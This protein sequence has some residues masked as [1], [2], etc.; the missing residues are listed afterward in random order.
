MQQELSTQRITSAYIH[1]QIR[2]VHMQKI[3]FYY[4]NLIYIQLQ[5]F[6]TKQMTLPSYASNALRA[7]RQR[8]RHKSVDRWVDKQVYYVRTVD[9]HLEDIYGVVDA[10]E[11][12]FSSRRE[13]HALHCDRHR[14]RAR[15]RMQRDVAK[16][17]KREDNLSS[18]IHPRALS[19]RADAPESTR[20]PYR[21]G[22]HIHRGG[23][24]CT[25]LHRRCIHQ[26][27]S[28]NPCR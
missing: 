17:L 25:S 13:R 12:P 16:S 18:G 10:V 2:E 20:V 7:S 27:A 22:R 15:L 9:R 3:K 21:L 5:D 4:A 28:V 6:I 19:E 8:G 26:C 14:E 11:N 1:T 23:T 24:R